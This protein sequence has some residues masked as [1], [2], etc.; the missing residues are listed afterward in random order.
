MIRDPL[1]ILGGEG[2]VFGP[3]RISDPRTTYYTICSAKA[4]CFF[5]AVLTPALC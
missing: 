1:I 3:S 5:G 2:G 4:E